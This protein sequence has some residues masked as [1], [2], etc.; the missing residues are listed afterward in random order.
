[1]NVTTF[2]VIVLMA[3]CALVL[4]TDGANVD[5]VFA[6]PNGTLQ[7]DKDFENCIIM[8]VRLLEYSIDRIN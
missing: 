8:F 6:T 7:V 4:I 2:L 3:N 5:N 1:M